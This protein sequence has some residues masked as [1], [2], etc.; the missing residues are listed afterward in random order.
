[1]DCQFTTKI[2][3]RLR[4]L[5][6]LLQFS[7]MTAQRVPSF[8]TLL[9]DLAHTIKVKSWDQTI[10]ELKDTIKLELGFDV[11]IQNLTYRAKP[12]RD[13]YFLQGQVSNPKVCILKTTRSDGTLLFSYSFG[14]AEEALDNP[15]IWDLRTLL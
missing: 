1:M 7:S 10:A 14:C 4:C 12:L 13:G 11:G 8:Q 6:L 9:T 15:T 5:I 3:G 2:L